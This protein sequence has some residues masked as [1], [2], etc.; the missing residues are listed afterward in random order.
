MGFVDKGPPRMQG[1][2]F[3]FELGRGGQQFSI[4]VKKSWIFWGVALPVSTCPILASHMSQD[5]WPC[6]GEGPW[7]SSKGRAMVV[8]KAI[9]SSHRPSSIVW[10]ENGPCCGTIA[11]FVGIKEGRIWFNTICLKLYQFNRNTWWRL[12]V[13]EFILKYALQYVLKFVMLD[14][15]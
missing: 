3:F 13:M 8:G 1:Q 10:S 9:F 6:N 15:F 7:L 11:Y 2:W 12:S 5:L 4:W 14:F